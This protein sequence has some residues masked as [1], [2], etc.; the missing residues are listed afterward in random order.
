MLLCT[1]QDRRY[2]HC[3]DNPDEDQERERKAGISL[4]VAVDGHGLVRGC[5]DG[6]D[7][8]ANHGEGDQQEVEATFLSATAFIGLVQLDSRS[9]LEQRLRTISDTQ[10]LCRCYRRWR[11]RR[12]FGDEKDRQRHHGEDYRDDERLLGVVCGQVKRWYISSVAQ[13]NAYRVDPQAAPLLH[14]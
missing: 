1:I 3:R 12:L 9:V 2:D 10:A 7:T 11:C 13:S 8:T 14:C 4:R 5:G 6:L